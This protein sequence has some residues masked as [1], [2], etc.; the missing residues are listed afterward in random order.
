[1]S[2]VGKRYVPKVGREIYYFCRVYRLNTPGDALIP[3][4]QYGGTDG[5]SHTISIHQKALL[6]YYLI[7]SFQFE[8]V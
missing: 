6:T 4:S 8:R 1:M 7:R 5:S 2:R 3:M